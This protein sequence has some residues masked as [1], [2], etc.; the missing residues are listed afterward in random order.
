MALRRASDHD[1]HECTK[2][3]AVSRGPSAYGKDDAQRTRSIE[4]PKFHR[5]PPSSDTL[6]D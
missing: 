6:N 4:L 5:T 3:R 1:Q 2:G